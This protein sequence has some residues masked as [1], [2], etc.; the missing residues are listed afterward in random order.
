MFAGAL[1]KGFS[2]ALPVL[3]IWL[4]LAFLASFFSVKE[5]EDSYYPNIF[6]NYLTQQIKSRALV[7]CINFASILIGSLIVLRITLNQEIVEKANLFPAWLYLTLGIAAVQPHQISTQAITNVFV[8]FSL[9]RLLGTYR[10]EKVLDALFSSAFWLSFSAFVAVYSI[11]CFPLFFIALIIMRPFSLKEWIMSILG[12]M[13]PVFLY[14][15]IAYLSDFN[16]WY[17]V[18]A[19]VMFIDYLKK[20]FLSEYYLPLII[21]LVVLLLLSFISG[22]VRGFG[23]TVK[24]QK[25]KS[26]LIWYLVL[27]S[28]GFFSGGAT[29]SRI[30]LTFAPPL[31]FFV[32]DFIF[33]IR[34]EK[35]T[36]TII[37]LLIASVLLIYL[38]HFDLV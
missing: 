19:V 21:L 28:I 20:P 22:L 34:Q 1:N 3:G 6:Y 36:N 26:I 14:E 10:E 18:D 33:N 5:L 16:Q 13:A 12:F 30:I 23:N 25:S 8:L 24:K 32:G 7:V 9:H 4:L 37:V 17:F 31:C 29:A 35:V 2:K 11:I 38:G 27:A 15:C